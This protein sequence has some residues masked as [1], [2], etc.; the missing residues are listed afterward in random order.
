MIIVVRD[1]HFSNNNDA[2]APPSGPI[3]DSSEPRDH[4]QAQV[5]SQDDL[6]AQAEVFVTNSIPV[7]CPDSLREEIYDVFEA[8]KAIC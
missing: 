7:E 6:V 2:S 8:C 4:L 5:V 1:H 3:C